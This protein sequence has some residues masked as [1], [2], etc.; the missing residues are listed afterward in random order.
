MRRGCICLSARNVVPCYFQLR[1]PPISTSI[2]ISLFWCTTVHFQDAM[3]TYTACAPCTP[4][5]RST[6]AALRA[7]GPSGTGLSYFKTWLR[8]TANTAF[9]ITC[10]HTD[11][12]TGYPQA[13]HGPALGAPIRALFAAHSPATATWYTAQAHSHHVMWRISRRLGE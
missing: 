1:N 10:L 13:P 8:C 6:A 3:V 12:I 9:V 2:T 5:A 4:R 7:S 11:Y